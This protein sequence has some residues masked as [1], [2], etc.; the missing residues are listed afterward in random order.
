M[1]AAVE[2]EADRIVVPVAL[3]ER[4]YEILI[5]DDLIGEAGAFVNAAVA[6][7]QVAVVTDENVAPLH[8]ARLEA[9][10]KAAGIAVFSHVLPAGE[11]TKSFA[12]LEDLL[13]RL[14]ADGIE[15]GDCVVALGGGVIGDL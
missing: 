15:R 3:G 14:L 1:T 5:G 4:S 6:P 2:T 10:L 9:S 7:R 13:D 8:L 12:A 11:G